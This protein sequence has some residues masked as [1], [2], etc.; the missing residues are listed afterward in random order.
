[1]SRNCRWRRFFIFK[2]AHFVFMLILFLTHC[3]L[4]II[5]LLIIVSILILLLLLILNWWWLPIWFSLCLWP[6]KLIDKSFLLNHFIVVYI[7]IIWVRYLSQNLRRILVIFR[8][9][10]LFS[11]RTALFRFRLWFLTIMF[12][13]LNL[14][15]NF[16]KL[17]VLSITE[18]NRP[19][20]LFV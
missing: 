19:L 15:I 10:L 9:F 12:F 6:S 18:L 16:F 4:I 20:R 13:W 17:Y 3:H 14:L 2:M 7:V 8:R 1:M 11:L 5:C